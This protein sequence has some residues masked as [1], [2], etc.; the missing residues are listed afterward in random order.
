M[1]RVADR[2]AKKS[3]GSAARHA[4]SNPFGLSAHRHDGARLIALAAIDQHGGVI[5]RLLAPAGAPRP[6]RLPPAPHS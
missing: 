5:A 4:Q 3:R 6:P 2:R 1:R